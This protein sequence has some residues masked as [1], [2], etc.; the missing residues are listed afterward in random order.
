[1]TEPQDVGGASRLLS[2]IR[3]QNDLIGWHMPISSSNRRRAFLIFHGAV[4]FGLGPAD[5]VRWMRAEGTQLLEQLYARDNYQ[6]RAIPCGIA[7]S[8]GSWFRREIRSPN[9]FR[10][11]K[12]RSVGLAGNVLQRLG[13][14]GAGSQVTDLGAAFAA[15]TV[16]AALFST[17]LTSV[18][19]KTPPPAA[20][21]HFPSWHAPAYL[22]DLLIG[23][24]QWSAMSEPQQRLVDEAC[25]RNLDKWAVQFDSSQTEVLTQVRNQR[26]LVRPFTGP[27]LEALRKAT[28]EV[29]AEE[30]GRDPEFKEVLDSYNRFRR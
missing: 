4:P 24:Q 5:H 21:F 30:A 2:A 28:E 12:V 17:A 8:T 7:G 18:F 3:D 29:L 13:A 27:T 10:G 25:R 20:V 23:A 22:F 9:D 26:I 15:N 6:F 1:V 11:L 19:V 16:D 14:E